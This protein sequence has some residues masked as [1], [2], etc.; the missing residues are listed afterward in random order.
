MVYLGRS[1]QNELMRSNNFY[2]KVPVTMCTEVEAQPN[3]CENKASVG[4]NVKIPS[5]G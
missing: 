3:N 5:R 2:V 1:C 4:T